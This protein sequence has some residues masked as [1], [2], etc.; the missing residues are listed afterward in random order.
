[1]SD[2]EKRMV[3]AISCTNEEGWA[4]LTYLKE[5]VGFTFVGGQE[6]MK[7][8]SFLTWAERP[9]KIRPLDLTEKEIQ[10]L[11][12]EAERGYDV[13]RMKGSPDHH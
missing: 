3:I 10:E 12:A 6:Y 11:R 2:D 9:M 5:K 1:M 4:L 13:Y 7:G 8:E